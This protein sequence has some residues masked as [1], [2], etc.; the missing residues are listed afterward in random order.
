MVDSFINI[1]IDLPVDFTVIER[2]RITAKDT[3]ERLIGQILELFFSKYVKNPHRDNY[4][5][6]LGLHKKYVLP[7]LLLL[8][9]KD[10]LLSAS[11][12]IFRPFFSKQLTIHCLNHR[13]LVSVD[14]CYNTFAIILIA[15][16][17]FRKLEL[18]FFKSVPQFD[19]FEN[20]VLLDLND[21]PVGN[22]VVMKPHADYKRKSQKFFERTFI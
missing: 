11:S 21:I 1:Q 5:I 16:K 18:L 14:P 22:M 9:I 7:N 13:L 3:G 15:Q 19:L 8:E 12:V 20:N 10:Q 17:E 6:Y 4:G 2:F